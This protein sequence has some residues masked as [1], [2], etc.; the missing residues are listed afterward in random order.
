M[1][2]VGRRGGVGVERA[3]AGQPNGVQPPVH[4]LL[5][6]EEIDGLPQRLRG[7]RGGDARFGADITRTAAHHADEL[8]AAAF[9]AAVEW[10]H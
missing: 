3:E 7:C 9:D 6:V 4:C 10:G 5:L 8:G 1:Q 2:P